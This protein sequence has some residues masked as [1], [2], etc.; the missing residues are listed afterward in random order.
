MYIIY[1]V[2]DWGGGTLGSTGSSSTGTAGSKL[3]H[4]PSRGPRP[5]ASRITSIE[6][7]NGHDVSLLLAASDD[8]SLRLWRDYSCPYTPQFSMGPASSS[9][10]ASGI[11]SQSQPRLVSAWQAISDIS[12]PAMAARQVVVT[13]DVRIIRLWDAERELRLQDLPTGADSCVTGVSSDSIGCVVYHVIN[14]HSKEGESPPTGSQTDLHR[15]STRSSQLSSRVRKNMPNTIS[16]ETDDTGGVRKPLVSTQFVEWSCKYF[17]QPVMKFLEDDD[18]ESKQ[19]YEREWRYMRNT[20]LR[21][22]AKEEQKRLAIGAK[23]E[24]QIFNARSSDPPSVI[25]FHPYENH[26]VVAG[27]DCFGPFWFCSGGPLLVVGCGDG[28][29]RLFD[30]RM[31]PQ[32]SRVM[33]WREHTGWVVGAHLRTDLPSAGRVISG[34]VAGDVRFFDLRRN[35]SVGL[36][37][38]SQGMTAMAVHPEA[39]CFSCGSVNQFISIY[40]T[41]GVLQNVIK[42]HEGF[43]SQRIKPVSCLA[44]H[45]H[46]VCLAAGSM[47]SS[48]GVYSL[49]LRR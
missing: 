10:H 39:D 4:C 31:G 33:T 30:R 27:K 38:T 44:F 17:A 43:M 26:L 29:V 36:C 21:K 37:Q 11:S 18:V 23:V 49:D 1:W 28:S 22:E 6:F 41:N 45:A 2:W 8:G 13:G 42:Y 35:S 9:I 34:S 16:E 19:H 20:H 46:R 3:S 5:G 15:L 24:S 40:N 12:Q 14:N 7:V 25:K 47:D 48:I 32:E